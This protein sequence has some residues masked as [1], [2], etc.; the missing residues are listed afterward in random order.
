MEFEKTGSIWKVNVELP[1]AEAR[2]PAGS[3]LQFMA[4][5]NEHMALP[6]DEMQRQVAIRVFRSISDGRAVEGKV[7]TLLMS[8][9]VLQEPSVRA[10]KPGA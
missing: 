5:P 9:G 3:V 10:I 2:N 1:K 8:D 7:L 6:S 4:V